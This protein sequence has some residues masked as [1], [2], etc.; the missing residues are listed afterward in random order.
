VK[1]H[2]IHHSTFYTGF[3]LFDAAGGWSF[4]HL[5][6][7]HMSTAGLT[8]TASLESPVIYCGL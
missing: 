7:P 3:I 1:K 8:P 6:S 4:S 2:L 5:V